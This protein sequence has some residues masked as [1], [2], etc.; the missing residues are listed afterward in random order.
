MVPAVAP[1]PRVTHPRWSRHWSLDCLGGAAGTSSLRGRIV[2]C[3]TART[4]CRVKTVRGCR[5]KKGIPLFSTDL[6]AVAD[7]AGTHELGSGSGSGRVRVKTGRAGL[8]A[9][10]GHD[11]GFP[12]VREGILTLNGASRPSRLE[13]T[14][15][16]IPNG[17][18]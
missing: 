1:P 13:V 14:I 15:K 5:S 4:D 6:R 11:P 17:S 7:L 10:A 16:E 18:A 12:P 9:R 3:R 8:A 2:G